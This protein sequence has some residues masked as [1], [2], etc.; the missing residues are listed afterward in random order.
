MNHFAYRLLPSRPTFAGDMSGAEA[1][2][3][4]RH[5]ASWQQ[6][7]EDGK[8]LVFGPVADPAGGWGLAVVVADTEADV[9]EMARADPA[10]V[11]GLC[12]FEVLA[13]PGAVTR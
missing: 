12:T 9:L 13:M 5:G 3:M 11:S 7:L 2:T 10:I 6:H 8:V 4:G 1:A